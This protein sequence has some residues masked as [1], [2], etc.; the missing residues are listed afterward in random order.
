MPHY[1]EIAIGLPV[2]GMKRTNAK[3][4]AR[5]RILSDP[6]FLPSKTCGPKNPSRLP[7]KSVL[8][9]YIENRSSLFAV[10]NAFPSVWTVRN[11]SYDFRVA[12]IRENSELLLLRPESPEFEFAPGR[13]AL[14]VKGQ[15]Y[16]FTVAGEITETA[17]CLERT[18][19]ANGTFY[20]ECRTLD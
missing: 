12:P 1:F 6:H 20:S 10:E 15:A 14:V 18:E 19:A 7:Q 8:F 2:R 13:Y 4:R 5:R 17:Q 16:D 9:F 3:E 11:I